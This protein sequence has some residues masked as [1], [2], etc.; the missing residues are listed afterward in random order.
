MLKNMQINDNFRIIF[1]DTQY[2]SVVEDI[3]EE[4]YLINIP[5][6]EGSEYLMLQQGQ[7]IEIDFVKDGGYY[8]FTSEVIGNHIENSKQF[9]KITVPKEAEKIEQRDFVRVN[10]VDYIF[11]K[12]KDKWNKAMVMDIR[13]G[14]MDLKIKEQGKAGDEIIIGVAFGNESYQ[15]KGNI[16]RVRINENKENICSIEFIDMSEKIREKIIAKTFEKLRRQL[17]FK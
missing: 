9:Y 1:D 5:I 13:A 10:F 16:V 15:L 6:A 8:I 2:K 3:Q 11:Y 14:G 17:E 12:F 7:K 4:Y